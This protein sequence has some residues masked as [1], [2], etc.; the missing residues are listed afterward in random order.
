MNKNIYVGG[1]LQ[2]PSTLKYTQFNVMMFKDKEGRTMLSINSGITRITVPFE[3]V[4][5][6]MAEW[7]KEND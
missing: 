6:A 7:R 5:E 1:I 3:Q 2:N 4:L